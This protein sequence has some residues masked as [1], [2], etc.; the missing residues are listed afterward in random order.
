[1]PITETNGK[2]THKSTRSDTRV[3]QWFCG[4]GIQSLIVSVQ[5]IRS[6]KCSAWN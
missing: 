5:H 4:F 3:S 2:P 1:M 6:V